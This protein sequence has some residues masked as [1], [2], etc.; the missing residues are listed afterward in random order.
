MDDR[1]EVGYIMKGFPRLSEV[2]ISNEVHLLEG[3]GLR[4]QIFALQSLSE[5]KVHAQVGEIQARVSYLPENAAAADAP[6]GIWLRANF[7]LLWSGHGKLLKRRT[8]PYLKTFLSAAQF[9]VKY[10]SSM[11]RLKKSFFKDFLRAGHIAAQVID[12]ETVGHLHGHFCH[13]SATIT[14][15]VSQITGIPFSFTAHAK[16]I[17]LPELNPGD[18]LPKKIRLAKFVATCTDANRLHLQRLCPEVRSIR[19]VYHGLSTAFFNPA[20][21]HEESGTPTILSVGRFV[22]KKGFPVLVEACSLLHEKNHDFRCRI[23]GAADEDS[24]PVQRL[25]A[26]YHLEHR[27]FL[28]GPVSQEELKQIY[29]E[30][31]IFALPCLVA[32]NGDR[33]GIP[34]VLVEA[35]AMA[36]PVVA[37]EVSGIPELIDHGIDGLLVPPQDP[38]GLAGALSVL[39]QD[40]ALRLRLGREAR[41]TVCARFDSSKTTVLLRDLFESCLNERLRGAA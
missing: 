24:E 11:W 28:E 21:A 13:G 32:G 4:L 9:S 26:K 2:F 27:V 8:L 37:T 34:N 41:Q 19:T 5:K 40:R 22:K 1:L 30:C 14:M 23:V 20:P 3:M 12:S 10:R 38:H 29:R 25:I 16:D 31:T 7:A 17:Y 33:D 6:F 15:W 35:M 39:L 18:L 36:K